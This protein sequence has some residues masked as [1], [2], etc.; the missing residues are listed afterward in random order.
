MGCKRKGRVKEEGRW[1]WWTAHSAR[2]IYIF[3]ESGASPTQFVFNYSHKVSHDI[4]NSHGRAQ[5]VQRRPPSAY[6]SALPAS[7]STPR[8]WRPDNFLPKEAPRAACSTSVNR[9]RARASQP[10]T[11]PQPCWSVHGRRLW[12]ARATGERITPHEFRKASGLVPSTS[13]RPRPFPSP[14]THNVQPSRRVQPS[15]SPCSRLSSEASQAASASQ[16]E[17]VSQQRSSPEAS[18]PAAQ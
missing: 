1:R 6:H 15:H 9:F 11:W 7:P 8:C 10:R 17:S 14:T 16:P 3:S 2:V 4:V 5:L 13:S 12:L 18:P